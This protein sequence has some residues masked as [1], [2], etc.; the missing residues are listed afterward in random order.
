MY[1]EYN[2][3][4]LEYT[5]TGLQYKN[6]LVLHYA[7]T[8]VPVAYIQLPLGAHTTCRTVR[9]CSYPVELVAPCRTPPL[10]S[11]VLLY[12]SSTTTPVLSTLLAAFLTFF[13]ITFTKPIRV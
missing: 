3:L 5:S 10:L 1:S 7:T 11:T 6:V 8:I 13:S 9:Y 4:V 12:Y 2:V